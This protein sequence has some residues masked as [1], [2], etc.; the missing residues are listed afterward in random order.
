MDGIYTE[1]DRCPK[2]LVADLVELNHTLICP[3]CHNFTETGFTIG[4]IGSSVVFSSKVNSGN[5]KVSD[6]FRWF[7]VVEGQICPIDRC[8]GKLVM[9]KSY[10]RGVLAFWLICSDN[11][12]HN[13]KVPLIEILAPDFGSGHYNVFV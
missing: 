7:G 10:I 1:S 11:A 3:N 9:R 2:C 6:R 13:T 4:L 8:L 12:D 5:T